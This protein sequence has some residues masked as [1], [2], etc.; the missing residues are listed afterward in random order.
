MHTCLLQVPIS[1]V[2]ERSL[3]LPE[4]AASHGPRVREV[5]STDL[6]LALSRGGHVDDSGMP[7][8]SVLKTVQRT[9]RSWHGRVSKAAY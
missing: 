2:E 5:T 4:M 9:R 8:R 3:Q 6:Q 7:S 1:D